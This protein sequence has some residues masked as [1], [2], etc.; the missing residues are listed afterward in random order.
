M[1]VLDLKVSS[2]TQKTNLYVEGNLRKVILFNLPDSHQATLTKEYLL[3]KGY[4][5]EDCY[6]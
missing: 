4:I 2:W 5:T 6:N 3:I 1:A